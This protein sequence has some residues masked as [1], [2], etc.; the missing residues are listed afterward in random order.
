MTDQVIPPR[1]VLLVEDEAM[2]RGLIA[3]VLTA[4][5][6]DVF[7]A[8]TADEAIDA[9]IAV[10]PDALVTDI[11]LGA[12]ATGLDLVVSL[13]ARNPHLPVVVLSNYVIT[14]DYTNPVLARAAYLRKK[15]LS[16]TGALLVALDTVLRE[17]GSPRAPDRGLG[18]R[19]AGLTTAQ[20]H[21]LRMIAVGMSNA[22]IA[23]RRRCSLRAA[24]HMV[25]RTFMAL[26]LGT[27]PRAN[28]R[29][30]AAR[31]YIEEAGMPAIDEETPEEF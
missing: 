6:F 18:G 24:E 14:P 17:Q 26:E 31:I 29:V 21:V 19:L 16:D 9:F 4:A 12:G 28:T 3:A 10:D 11:D 5:G 1:S 23:E 20:I 25:Q 7:T 27:D 30:I 13:S 22:E 15:D 2:S 8:A